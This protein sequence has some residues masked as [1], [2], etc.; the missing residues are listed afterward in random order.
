MKVICRDRR[1]I[2]KSSS[3]QRS[4]GMSS[5]SPD[6]DKLLA[7]K[8]YAQL[9]TL[10]KQ[11]KQKLRSDEP[12]DV[13]Y[14]ENLL[15]HISIYK[16]KARLREVS[17]TVVGAR[18][19]TLRK[20]QEQAAEGLRNEITEQIGTV[21]QHSTEHNGGNAASEGITNCDP[22][23]LLRLNPEDKGF[24]SLDVADFSTKLVSSTIRKLSVLRNS[25]SH[26]F[27]RDDES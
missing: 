9:E 3:G 4:R 19:D 23:P 10:E 5:V 27:T 26:R 13:D 11:V 12:I 16:A 2:L 7:P 6:L 22:E 18:L 1:E 25:P 15:R 8:N 24:A 21:T 17:Q 14:W 20:Q